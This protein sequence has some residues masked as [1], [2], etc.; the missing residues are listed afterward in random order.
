MVIRKHSQRKK[1]FDLAGRIG[2][3]DTA[4][5]QLVCHVR[6]WLCCADEHE[7]P[8]AREKGMDSVC[9]FVCQSVQLDRLLTTWGGL[10]A[11]A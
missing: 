2:F 4:P 5:R 11:S 1:I 7:L 8:W 10:A 9:C 6:L 3:D